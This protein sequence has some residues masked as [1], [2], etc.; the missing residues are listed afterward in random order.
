MKAQPPTIEEALSYWF[1]CC[2]KR[3]NNLFVVGGVVRDRL[4]GFPP[5]DVDL[6]CD[7]ARQVAEALAGQKGAVMVPF[8]KK[9]ESPCFRVIDR[10][11][12]VFSIDIAPLKGGD[13]SVD[14][15]ARDF[16]VNAMAL[17][18]TLDLRPGNLV[19]PFDG[20]GD[21][22][23][24]LVRMVSTDAFRND[25]LRVFR[26]FRLAASLG[27]QIGSETLAEAHRCSSFLNEAAGERILNELKMFLG[28]RNV[29]LLAAEM[30]ETGAVNALFPEKA[31]TKGQI[32]Q[33]GESDCTALALVEYH[34]EN[35]EKIF[36]PFT[37]T[38]TEILLQP[39]R[40]FLLKTAALLMDSLGAFTTETA[41][42]VAERLHMPRKM[43]ET[44]L[45]L[46]SGYRFFLAD[47]PLEVSE[48]WNVECFRTI[49]D[50][51]VAAS[52]LAM[53]AAGETG[54]GDVYTR[55]IKWAVSK[56]LLELRR[57]FSRPSLVSGKELVSIGIPVG[58]RLGEILKQVRNAQDLGEVSTREGAVRLA[59][60]L[61]EQG[62]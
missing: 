7:D 35:P 37:H 57:I 32:P 1:R 27:F 55:K 46:A 56:Y 42:M 58:P 31:E 51:T 36:G 23:R 41:D 53:A 29:S 11:N 25:P 14:L 60:K 54:P 16:T 15:A 19:D 17:E 59:R 40:R 8:T 6:V 45:L 21:L 28:E 26:A 22:R 47:A 33:A 43:R 3:I 50:E 20:A 4:L 12:P 10:R 2:P 38:A 48:V 13:I 5:G 61:Y 49:G 44:L 24:R 52:I 18:V 39:Q 9:K 62:L 34:L 30:I